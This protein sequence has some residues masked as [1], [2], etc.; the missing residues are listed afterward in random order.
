M[1]NQTFPQLGKN[2]LDIIDETIGNILSFLNVNVLSDDEDCDAILQFDLTLTAIGQ[3][4]RGSDHPCF[5]GVQ[6]QGQVELLLSGKKPITKVLE[7]IE[8]PDT[9]TMV[10]P[11]ESEAH[12]DLAWQPAVVEGLTYFWGSMVL[13]P[14][15]GLNLYKAL[16]VLERTQ[17]DPETIQSFIQM[18]GSEYE[19]ARIDASQALGFMGMHEGIVPALIQ[20]L[21]DTNDTVR[22]NA[23]QA[24]QKITGQNFGYQPDAWNTWWKSTQ[25][26]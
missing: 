16:S 9:T 24:L 21:E 15:V 13:V 7:A 4:Y 18:L 20:A 14:A 2:H 23:L 26:Q 3:E 5:T 11:Y 12:F 6:A 22:F 17:T 1:V 25:D 8:P 10:C 19:T